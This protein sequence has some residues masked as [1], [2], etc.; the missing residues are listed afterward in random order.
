M[1]QVVEGMRWKQSRVKTISLDDGEKGGAPHA[2]RPDFDSV[3]NTKLQLLL[4]TND[5][6]EQAGVYAKLSSSCVC[7]GG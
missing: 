6:R 5:S 1:K 3:L 2:E 4:T 7:H